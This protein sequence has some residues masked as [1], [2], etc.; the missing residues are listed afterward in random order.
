[1]PFPR[2][3]EFGPEMPF[4]RLLCKKK[5]MQKGFL[6]LELLYVKKTRQNGSD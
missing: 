6:T 2:L 4:P 5:P 3:L 1:M